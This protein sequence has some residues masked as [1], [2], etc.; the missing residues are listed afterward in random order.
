MR[1]SSTVR[2][3]IT[4]SLDPV[5]PFRL[6]LTVWT[7]RRRADNRVDRW[8]GQTYRRALALDGIPVEAVVTQPGAADAPRLH[9]TLSG[10]RPLTRDGESG[11]GGP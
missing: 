1:T 5:P 3:K 11:A 9:V 7:L 4:F 8:D 10:A 2:D 6:D